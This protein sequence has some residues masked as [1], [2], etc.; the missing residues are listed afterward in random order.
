MLCYLC[1]LKW[2][3]IG[4]VG[5]ILALVGAIVF[6]SKRDRMHWRVV[7]THF[8]VVLTRVTC[9]TKLPVA[10]FNRARHTWLLNLSVAHAQV[11]AYCVN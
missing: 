3:A 2:A 6:Y 4:L 11:P 10:K 1:V 9:H 5:L 7:L 8:L